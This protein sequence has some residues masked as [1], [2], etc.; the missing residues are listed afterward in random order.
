MCFLLGGYTNRSIYI[1]T[2]CYKQFKFIKFRFKTEIESFTF[3]IS[4]L[5]VALL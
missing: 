1:I 2:R 3:E 4:C 5:K